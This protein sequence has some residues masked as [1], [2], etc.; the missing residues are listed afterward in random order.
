MTREAGMMILIKLLRLSGPRADVTSP[1][2]YADLGTRFG[3]SR[4]Q[5][6]T[7]LEEAERDGLMRLPR[8]KDQLVQLTAPLIEA[9][10][11]FIADTMEAHDLIYNLAQR[12]C[13]K[14]PGSRSMQTVPLR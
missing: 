11:A 8:G 4:T 10:D 12:A 3:V 6:R 7:L 9:F 1:I 14:S 5:V 2:S 13:G